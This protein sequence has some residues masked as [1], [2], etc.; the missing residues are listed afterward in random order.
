MQLQIRSVKTWISILQYDGV[1]T[2]VPS[3]LT[4]YDKPSVFSVKCS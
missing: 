3:V 2:T 4:A 1:Q